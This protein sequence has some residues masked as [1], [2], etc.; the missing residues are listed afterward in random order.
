VK[1]FTEITK[2]E[3]GINRKRGNNPAVFYRTQDREMKLPLP[4]ELPADQVQLW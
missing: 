2:E 3:S 4:Q 1:N